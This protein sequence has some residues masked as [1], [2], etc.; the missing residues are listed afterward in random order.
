[1]KFKFM[2]GFTMIWYEICIKAL[3]MY[4]NNDYYIDLGD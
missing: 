4:A 1:M 2:I 3:K